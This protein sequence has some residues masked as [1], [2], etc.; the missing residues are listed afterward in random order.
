MLARM[1]GKTFVAK[2]RNRCADKAV[3][4][5]E[6]GAPRMLAPIEAAEDMFLAKGYHAATMSDVAAAA[7]MS[8]KTVYTMIK[9]KAELFNKLLAHHGSLLDFPT[10]EPGWTTRDILNANLLSL[11]R[12]LL[13]P[14]Q[15]AILRLI[16]AE[17]THSPDLGRLF[18]RNRILKAKAKLENCL[19]ELAKKEGCQGG[20]A[21]EMAAML[22]GMAIGEF[23]LSVLIGYRQAPTKQM[24]EKRIRRAVDIFMSGCGEANT[25]LQAPTDE[26]A[27]TR[28]TL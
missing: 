2:L 24:L 23:H 26:C 21:K 7:G 8:K 14:G 4:E 16:M 3:S 10:P 20:D 9:S 22:F 17:Y 18:L 25:P 6:D 19:V 5:A 28:S 11:G 27:L 13:S 15:I 12:F 1:M